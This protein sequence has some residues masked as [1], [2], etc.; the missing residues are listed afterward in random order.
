MTE[1]KQKKLLAY[2]DWNLENDFQ[3]TDEELYKEFES[4]WGTELVPD[5]QDAVFFFRIFQQNLI[6]NNKWKFDVEIQ[7]FFK[8]KELWDKV[9]V[10]KLID[11][12]RIKTNTPRKEENSTRMENEWT[13]ETWKA[14]W[15]GTNTWKIEVEKINVEKIK[16]EKKEEV[17]NEQEKPKENNKDQ[18]TKPGWNILWAWQWTWSLETL[19]WTVENPRKY[20]LQEFDLNF[21]FFLALWL[22]GTLFLIKF[23][24]FRIIK[25][26]F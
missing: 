21:V 14:E 17:K 22:A 15:E 8:L 5:K 13:N 19:T 16:N 2:V 9:W 23:W 20:D 12:L 11:S 7:E 26:A 10:K 1:I 24:I 18:P 25:N 4:M 3:K 6:W